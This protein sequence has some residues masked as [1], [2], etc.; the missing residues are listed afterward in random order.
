V[1]RRASRLGRGSGE[2]SGTA[3]TTTA[4]RAESARGAR[5]GSSAPPVQTR[6]A[7]WEAR[8]VFRGGPE[9]LRQARTKKRFG[10]G[11]DA[12]ATTG[13]ASWTADDCEG[14]EPG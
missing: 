14:D 9:A 13:T 8:E 7:E 4:R 3:R 10:M 12:V 2:A 6:W 1:R 11:A 5:G